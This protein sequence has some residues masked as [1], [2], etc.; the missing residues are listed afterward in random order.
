M[1]CSP[2]LFPL[3][4]QLPPGFKVLFLV[5]RGPARYAWLKPYRLRERT[6]E[7][8]GSLPSLI[9]L[10][11]VL[12]FPSFEKM[13]LASRHCP[14]PVA[15]PCYQFRTRVVV[16]GGVMDECL[17]ARQRLC[18]IAESLR[19][20]KARIVPFSA[21]SMVRFSAGRRTP[22]LHYTTIDAS[23]LSLRPV[24]CKLYYTVF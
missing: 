3:P 9:L 5:F 17:E 2:E 15:C 8:G 21:R 1:T 20:E 18:L 24:L 7:R 19:G 22:T 16:V 14:N 13:I 11:P 6:Q 12:N 4:V 23:Q 10:Y